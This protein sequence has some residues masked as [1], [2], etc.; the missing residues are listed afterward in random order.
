MNL[1]TISHYMHVSDLEV[2]AERKIPKLDTSTF[3]AFDWFPKTI[4]IKEATHY[5][6]DELEKSK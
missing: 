1:V 5:T 3:K 4:K 2:G 6:F